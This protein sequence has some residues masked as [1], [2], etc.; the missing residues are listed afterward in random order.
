MIVINGQSTLKVKMSGSFT[1]K[2]ISGLHSRI[3]DLTCEQTNDG[4]YLD[5][6][7]D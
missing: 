7:G 1:Y 5:E 3:Y 4:I 2:V 6:L